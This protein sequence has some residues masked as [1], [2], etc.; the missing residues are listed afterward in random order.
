MR[1]QF[2]YPSGWQ[3]QKRW[4]QPEQTTDISLKMMQK[5]PASITAHYGIA[6]RPQRGT[7]LHTHWD[8]HYPPSNGIGE[9]VEKLTPVCTA[10]RNMKWG[11]TMENSTVPPQK[12]N[13]NGILT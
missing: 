9:D 13:K 2:F 6:N 12:Q 8:G 11:A 7:S 3:R 4:V 5:P 10:G 1:Y